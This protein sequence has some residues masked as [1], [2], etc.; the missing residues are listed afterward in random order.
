MTDLVLSATSER[1]TTITLN[2]PEARNALSS[3]L[4]TQLSTAIN[5]AEASEATDVII[6]T[7]ADPA[8]CAGLDL[9]ELG[10]AELNLVGGRDSAALSPFTALWS[11]TKPVIAAI[12]GACVTGGFELA[13]GCDILVA[14][15][16]ATFADTHARVGLV[17]A[18]GMSVFLQEAVGLRR[19]KEMSLTGNFMNAHDALRAHLVNRVVEHD[20]LMP[21]AIKIAADIASNDQKA[22]RALKRLYDENSQMTAHDALANERASFKNWRF[23]AAEIA[24]R[25]SDV[26]DRGRG[27]QQ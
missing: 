4:L 22:V 27:Q 15:E 17:P 6:L 7:G 16:R 9:R 12:N 18:G 10:S 20:D 3:A 14:S 5:D 21:T 19:A 24:R 25:R 2:R 13:L 11:T 26:V 23:D 8:F 1:V